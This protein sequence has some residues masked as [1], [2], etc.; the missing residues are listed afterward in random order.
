M[1]KCIHTCINP[2]SFIGRNSFVDDH[3]VEF[4]KLSQDRVIGTKDQVAHV[5]HQ[6]LLICLLGVS[7][8]FFNSFIFILCLTA[9]L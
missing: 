7:F 8:T 1:L 5:G 4:S 2:A 3:Y 9:D 6:S